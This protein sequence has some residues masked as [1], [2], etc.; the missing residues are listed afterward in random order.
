M[1]RIIKVIWAGLI[2][3]C[4]AGCT[5]VDRHGGDAE[6]AAAT[7]S[8]AVADTVVTAAERDSVVVDTIA[9]V[10]EDTSEKEGRLIKRSI[11]LTE[12]EFFPP[13]LKEAYETYIMKSGIM[14]DSEQNKDYYWYLTIYE[15]VFTFTCV[16]DLVNYG[17]YDWD[18]I[19][20]PVGYTT[21]NG[22]DVRVYLSYPELYKHI[23]VTKENPKTFTVEYMQYPKLVNEVGDYGGFG[24]IF[25]ALDLENIPKIGEEIEADKPIS[26]VFYPN[27]NMLWEERDKRNKI[28]A[29]ANDSVSTDTVRTDSV[30]ADSVAV[31]ALV[32]EK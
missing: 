16:N 2:L 8:A 14:G 24:E 3:D 32:D 19:R 11:T 29:E 9:A 18:P 7:D 1:K 23:I 28:K 5:G 4:V 21:I 10:Q 25:G 22:V 26:Y 6:I 31:A 20:H 12:V 13:G 30:R 17:N 15:E 27:G